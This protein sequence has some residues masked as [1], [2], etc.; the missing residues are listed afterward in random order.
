MLRGARV[1]QLRVFVRFD[2]TRSNAADRTRRSKAKRAGF[3]Q[4]CLLVAV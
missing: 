3:L 2:G 1:L 4:V